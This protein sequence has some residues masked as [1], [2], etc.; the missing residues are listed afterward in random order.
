VVLSKDPLT[1]KSTRYMLIEITLY[2][3]HGNRKITAL[4]NYRADKDLISQRFIKENNLK[5]TPV[6]RIKTTI[7]R[8][9]ITIYR[10]HNIITKIKDS[11][12]EVRA[13]QRTFYATNI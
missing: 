13:T 6:G 11:R 1:A 2:F 9:Y 3:S 8:H 12:N 4:F 5:T 10:F 7:N